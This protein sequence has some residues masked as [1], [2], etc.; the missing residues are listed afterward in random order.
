MMI[1]IIRKCITVFRVVLESFDYELLK[2]SFNSNGVVFNVIDA[3][4]IRNKRLY[5]I[6]KYSCKN[7]SYYNNAIKN[8]KITKENVLLIFQNIPVL[9]RELIL[10]NNEKLKSK[11]RF[12]FPN[13]ISKTSGT[14]G[15]PLEFLGSFPNGENSHQKFLYE[16][17]INKKVNYKKIISFGGSY[18]PEELTKNNVFWTETKPAN[19]YGTLLF[20][21]FYILEENMMA[22]INKLN[23]FQPEVIRSYPSC[24]L[25]FIDY[26]E[27]LNVRPNI[28]VKG[29]YLTSENA[30]KEQFKRIS[31]FFECGVYGQY[32]H[33]EACIFAFTKKNDDVY[34]C[35]P[36]YGYVEILDLNNKH[37]KIGE[38][39][40]VTVTTFRNRAMPFIRYRTGDLAVYGGEENGYVILSKLIGREKDYILNKDNEKIYIIVG[41]FS[42]C[43][44]P[45]ICHV[46]YWQAI[47]NEVGKM[48]LKIVKKD[49]YTEKDEKE[50]LKVVEDNKIETTIEYVDDIPLTK[51]GKRKYII[52]SLY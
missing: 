44:L 34:Y 8:K 17:M 10:S 19:I 37:V 29:I 13:G 49:I 21:S 2:K 46:K 23:E 39:G 18:L 25:L 42:E 48:H 7:C 50:I 43:F 4:K 36:F 9:T 16:F 1:K 47:Q 12:L 51:A 5:R 52:N 30:T 35:S 40:Y 31:D 11:L 33:S 14:T 22:Y 24:L 27:K 15:I 6:L 41:Q 45:A 28:K 26:C 20:S 3:N 32:G 38:T